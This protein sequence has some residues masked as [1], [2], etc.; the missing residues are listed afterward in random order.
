M[1]LIKCRY[2]GS[3]YEQKNAWKNLFRKPTMTDWIILMVVI[4]AIGVSFLYVQD[5][6]QCKA[7]VQKLND[8]PCQ[9]CTVLIDQNLSK[10]RP[11]IPPLPE[12]KLPLVSNQT[13]LQEAYNESKSSQ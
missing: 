3:E 5:T 11:S 4:F 13:A 12:L 8:N 2:C 6:K 10:Q 9:F 1:A 7:F